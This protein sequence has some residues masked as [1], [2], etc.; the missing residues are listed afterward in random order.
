MPDRYPKWEAE[1]KR[2]D[3]L[4]APIANGPVDLETL[5]VSFSKREKSTLRD[6]AE[7]AQAILGELL[8]EYLGGDDKVRDGLRE[9]FWRYENFAWAVNYKMQDNSSAE[10]KRYL[11]FL[12]MDDQGR[13]SRD[14]MMTCTAIF[15]N[16]E[17]IG[18]SYK[19]E[20]KEVVSVSST[21]NKYGMGSTAEI[22][23][24]WC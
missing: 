10:A 19:A 12:S 8:D 16:F 3:K 4:V 9:L 22:L 13:D 14:F 7:S 18:V 21:R 5:D 23:N 2:L 15:D 24:Q 20:L 17:E 1:I 11:A 6:V